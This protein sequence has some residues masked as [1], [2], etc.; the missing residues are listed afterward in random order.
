[1]DTKTNRTELIPLR[2]TPAEKALIQ[3]KAGGARKVSAYLRK[4]ALEDCGQP[5]PAAPTVAAATPDGR[6]FIPGPDHDRRVRDHARRMPQ[7][8]AERVVSR[9]EAREAAK[10]AL[11]S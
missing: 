10:A 6:K 5:R 1:V 2:A 8:T 3:E 7:K 4:L 11:R 9:E